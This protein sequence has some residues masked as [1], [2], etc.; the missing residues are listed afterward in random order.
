MI[1]KIRQPFCRDFNCDF[2]AGMENQKSQV[3]TKCQN[4][5][6]EKLV[7]SSCK[8]KFDLLVIKKYILTKL[9]SKT[10]PCKDWMLQEKL[11]CSTT[12]SNNKQQQLL[13][14]AEQA[15]TFASHFSNGRK[16]PRVFTE[17]SAL[18]LPRKCVELEK[19]SDEINS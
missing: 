18:G 3:K 14:P 5:I 9:E 15:E 12:A 4:N 1:G 7:T 10:A 19:H 16:L 13:K 2:E 8:N 6:R 11:C 17:E